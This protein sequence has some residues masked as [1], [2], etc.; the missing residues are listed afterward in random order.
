MPEGSASETER[1]RGPTVRWFELF[2][3]LVVVAAL[4]LC[5][6]AFL[7]APSWATAGAAVLGT[8]ALAWVWFLTTLVHNIAP[9]DDLLRRLLVLLQMAF[10]VVA[11]L[12]VNQRDGLSNSTGLLAYA[13]ALVVVAVLVARHRTLLR[14]QPLLRG[15]VV[16]VLLSAVVALVGGLLPDAQAGVVLLASLGISMVGILTV[17][18]RVVQAGGSLRADHLRE[19]RGIFILIILGEGFVQLVHD[20]SDMGTIPRAGVFAVVFLLSFSLWWIYFD[21]VFAPREGHVIVHWRTSLLA[22]L[23]LVYG[24]GGTLDILALL[25]ASHDDVLGDATLLYFAASLA[26][27]FV[28]FAV[29][30]WTANGTIGVSGWTQ[31]VS[32]ALTL[33]AG[34]AAT[35]RVADLPLTAVMTGAALLVVGNAVLA[36]VA[37]RRRETG[38]WRS[39]MAR[40]VADPE[41]G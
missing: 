14:T 34:L 39:A 27:V 29:L 5:N 19:R 10:I 41:E 25:A 33:A 40:A 26:V 6:D 13:G 17:P 23:T 16:L 36:V 35:R 20:L 2:Y 3:D 32:A 37:D 31:L 30:G 12:A 4:G 38:G 21:G 8:A 9:R 15:G 18:G 11:A 7:L 22:H 1:R 24:M 28:S